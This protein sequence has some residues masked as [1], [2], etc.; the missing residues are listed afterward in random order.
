MSKKLIHVMLGSLLLAGC[1]DTVKETLGLERITPDEFTV[2]ERAPLVVPPNFDLVPPADG[3]DIP[4]S[5]T[6][7]KD[8]V[9]G[10]QIS[11]PTTAASS[12]GSAAESLLLQK[13]GKAQ[14]DIR[15]KLSAEP[16]DV[17]EPET[18]AQKLGIVSTDAQGKAI[19][20]VVEAKKL[21]KKKIKTVPVKDT[22][23]TEI[24]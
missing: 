8:L 22:T 3:S 19:D 20:P 14:A 7:A 12:Q 17:A 24:K 6:N 21:H 13:A 1:G 4:A 15:Q 10:S 2:V 11:N 9:L 23:K 18:A 5:G 16:D